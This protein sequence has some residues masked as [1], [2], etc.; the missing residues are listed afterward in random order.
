MTILKNIY[1]LYF[2]HII[3]QNEVII[4]CLKL[5]YQTMKVGTPYEG[6]IKNYY[7]TLLLF[8]FSQLFCNPLLPI[9]LH[10]LRLR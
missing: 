3:K 10:L 1:L 8:L 4:T 6:V 7:F 9:T 5:F 2:F